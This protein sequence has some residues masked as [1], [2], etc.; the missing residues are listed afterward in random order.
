MAGAIQTKRAVNGGAKLNVLDVVNQKIECGGGNASER[1]RASDNLASPQS[2]Q[3]TICALG[4]KSN[5][6]EDCFFQVFP[7]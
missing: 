2:D 4:G 7:L 6:S 1:E 5:T 3:T